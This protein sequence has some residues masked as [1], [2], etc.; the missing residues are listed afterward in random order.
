M[1]NLKCRSPFDFNLMTNLVYTFVAVNE[2]EQ[3]EKHEQF[4]V[5]LFLH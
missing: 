1:L 3:S 5:F 4:Y 2:D